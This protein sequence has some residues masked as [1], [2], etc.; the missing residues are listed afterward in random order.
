MV[1]TT[2]VM[3]RELVR[4]VP[5]M[6]CPREKNQFKSMFMLVKYLYLLMVC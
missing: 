3:K 6:Y 2:A 1:T 4:I 5:K